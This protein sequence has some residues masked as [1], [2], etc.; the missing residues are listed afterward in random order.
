MACWISSSR[1]HTILTGPSTFCAI[2]TALPD[3]VD[4]QPTPEP[5][6]D[7]MVVDGDLVERQT[8]DFCCDCLRAGDDLIAYPDLARIRLDMKRAVHRLHGRMGQQGNVIGG[9]D[10]IAAQGRGLIADRFGDDAIALA[11]GSDLIENL[12]AAHRGIRGH[13][14]I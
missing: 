4:F 13:R 5:A 14:P 7:E 10:P 2:R 12:L 6:A 11:R 1:V 9:F 8:R 3:H